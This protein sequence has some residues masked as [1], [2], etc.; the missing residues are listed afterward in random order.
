M[1]ELRDR[2]TKQVVK[3]R[4]EAAVGEV[5]VARDRIMQE[6]ETAGGR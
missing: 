5:S 1:V 3:F 4:P 6:L 2:R